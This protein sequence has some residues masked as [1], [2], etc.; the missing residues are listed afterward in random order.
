MVVRLNKDALLE[1]QN[2]KDYRVGVEGDQAA[3]PGKI[4]EVDRIIGATK[5]QIADGGSTI[6]ISAS[7]SGKGHDPIPLD[8]EDN[9]APFTPTSRKGSLQDSPAQLDGG[10]TGPTP[11][12][13]IH[14][15]K[16]AD[17]GLSNRRRSS[18]KSPKKT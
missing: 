4:G 12:T 13:P 15:E 6:G 17:P 14:T 8:D 11:D 5:K 7:N 9:N 1:S 3:A 10:A 16:V 18:P 2:N